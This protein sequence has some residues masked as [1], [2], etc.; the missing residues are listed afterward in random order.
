MPAA[1]RLGVGNG[2]TALDR[3]IL[4]GLG[5]LSNQAA[6]LKRLFRGYATLRKNLEVLR[7]KW[8]IAHR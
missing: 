7:P 1:Q 3:K 6:L 8:L 2:T 5:S 4:V